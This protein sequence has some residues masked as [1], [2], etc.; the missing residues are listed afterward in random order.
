MKAQAWSLDFAV[1]VTIFFFMMAVLL[2]AW[3]YVSYQNQ[4]Q[5]AFNDMENLA[6]GISDELIRTRGLPE[7]WDDST[8]EVLGLASEENFLNESKVLMFVQMDYDKSR[9][10]LGITPYN[11]TFRVEQLNGSLIQSQGVDL[12]SGTSVVIPATRHV[13][14]DSRVVRMEFALW[15]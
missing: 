9:R 5:T 11:Y 7:N 10:L 15:Y 12:S 8:V 1:S 6:L 4:S 14:Y 3:Q 13:L 2:F